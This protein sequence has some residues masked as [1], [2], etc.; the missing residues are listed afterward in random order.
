MVLKIDTLHFNR[1]SIRSWAGAMCYCGSECFVPWK[2]IF[3][4]GCIP[5]W[6]CP[7]VSSQWRCSFLFI[8]CMSSVE[9]DCPCVSICLSFM[10]FCLSLL[11][12]ILW[13]CM[14]EN[15]MPWEYKI[16]TTWLSPS[17][18]QGQPRQLVHIRD[19]IC[20]HCEWPFELEDV[21]LR[22]FCEEI[23]RTLCKP[24]KQPLSIKFRNK[25][26]NSVC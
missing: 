10:S 26:Q 22:T 20:H 8:L 18:C 9:E 16:V 17:W 25:I 2:N 21:P 14:K 3:Y 23:Y 7:H 24:L 15:I 13:G 11:D 1:F 5:Q 6:L 19:L 4:R 12:F